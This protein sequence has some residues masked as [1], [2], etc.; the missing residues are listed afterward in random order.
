MSR[1]AYLVALIFSGK[2]LRIPN[3]TDLI[4]TQICPNRKN[5]MQVRQIK[6]YVR[7]ID[8]EWLTN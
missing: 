2:S 5:T 3:G 8:S 7:K 6:H 1:I 4:A